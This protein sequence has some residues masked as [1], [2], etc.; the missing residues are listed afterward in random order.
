VIG[1]HPVIGNTANGETPEARPT[2][3]EQCDSFAD[4]PDTVD[5]VLL[6][7][8]INDIGVA[9]ILNPFAWFRL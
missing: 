2:I 4:S 6:N 5:L 7:G 1:A 8:G 3:I 9:T